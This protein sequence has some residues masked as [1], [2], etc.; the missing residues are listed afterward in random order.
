MKSESSPKKK[1]TEIP[2]PKSTLLLSPRSEK[3]RLEKMKEEYDTRVVSQKQQSPPFNYSQ[4]PAVD[5]TKAVQAYGLI[6][7]AM[8]DHFN[9]FALGSASK[10]GNL[11]DDIISTDNHNNAADSFI[12]EL[13]NMSKKAVNS[14]AKS[15]NKILQRINRND[16]VSINYSPN[17]KL[18]SYSPPSYTK[19]TSPKKKSNQS[20]IN[21]STELRAS[22][23]SFMTGI[24]TN[25]Y[26]HHYHYYYYL[27]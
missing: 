15:S 12:N 26:H 8:G 1:K 22:P 18:D 14:H 25:I 6:E 20:N 24:S 4:A 7:S 23:I 19:I 17:P 9:P 16:D 13:T 11:L 10:G 27:P 2:I 21:T 3:L 5:M